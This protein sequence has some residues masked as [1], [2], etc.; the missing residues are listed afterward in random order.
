MAYPISSNEAAERFSFYG[1]K[2]ILIIFM[3]KFMMDASG[4][5]DYMTET[6]AKAWYHSFGTAVYAFPILGAIISDW[7]LGKYRTI[8]WLSIVYCF[9]HFALAIDE[10]RNGLMLGLILIAV[11]SGGIKPCVSAHVGDQFG[12]SNHHLL[13]KVF[14]WFYFAI[15]LGA[16]AST[17]LT[18]WLL[19]TYGPAYAFGIPGVLMVIATILFWMGRNKFIHI[20]AAGGAFIKEV[21]SKEGLGSLAKLFVIYVF[22]AMFWALFDQTGSAWVLQADK[23]D[24]YFLG[25]EWLPSQIHF[26]NPVMIMI[27]IPLFGFVIYP[28]INRVF[29]LTPIRKIAIGFFVT[30]PAFAVPAWIEAQIAAGEVVN[31]GW[32]LVAYAIITAAEVFISITCLEFSYTQAPKKMKSFV[33]A[34][35]LLS[36]SL[37]NI[38]VAGVNFFI[39][40]PAPSFE[41]DK[42]GTDKVELTVSD[43]THTVKTVED[44]EVVT[45][46][47]LEALEASDVETRKAKGKVTNPAVVDAGRDAR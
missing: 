6:E 28:A 23:M 12:K 3:T 27:F 31:I 16:A 7:V 42:A 33:M 41:A 19:R 2:G 40:N 46:V 43:G 14:G 32:Q 9:G 18:P 15:N 8:L 20:P 1:M 44:I 45:Q 13:E 26:V 37:G 24:R 29:P 34:C 17:V 10:T 4:N 11:G 36:V 39:Q 22:V 5:P 38:F 47:Q 30:V 25:I 35:F 21:F